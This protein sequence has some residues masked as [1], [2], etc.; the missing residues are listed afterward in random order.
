MS[1]SSS[2]GFHIQPVAK[3][4]IFITL[5]DLQ[6]PHVCMLS[7][8][9][10][11]GLLSFA[12]MILHVMCISSGYKCL[13]IVYASYQE[14]CL[15]S[16]DVSIYCKM[17]LQTSLHV[18]ILHPRHVILLELVFPFFLITF[19]WMEGSTSMMSLNLS[20]YCLFVV[21][22]SLEQVSSFFSCRRFYMIFPISQMHQFYD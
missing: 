19:S 14:S 22:Y 17:E 11:Q 3:F 12:H 4:K 1:L 13:F 6:A 20:Y 10:V 15:L 5:G 8:E 21:T 16:H 2:I 18:S 9:L 7:H